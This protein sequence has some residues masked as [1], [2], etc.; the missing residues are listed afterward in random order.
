MTNSNNNNWQTDKNVSGSKNN[1]TVDFDWN[2]SISEPDLTDASL[3]IDRFFIRHIHEHVSVDDLKYYRRKKPP[4][5]HTRSTICLYNEDEPVLPFSCFKSE[6]T[7]KFCIPKQTPSSRCLL[8][9]STSLHLEGSMNTKSEQ[10]SQYLPYSQ[11][12]I[13]SC[14][15]YPIKNPESLHFIG[16]TEMTLGEYRSSF[17]SYPMVDRTASILPREAFKVSED[18]KTTKSVT[19]L[20]NRPKRELMASRT[21]TQLS[22][23]GGSSFAPSEYRRQYVEFRIE[24][25]HSIPQLSH[26]KI[27]GDFKGI[28][29]Y[30]DNYRMYDS[31]SKS[32]PIKKADNLTISGEV[33]CSNEVPEY[34]EKFKNP[35]KITVEKPLKTQDHLHPRGE[36]TKDV[37]EYFES[38]RDPQVKDKPER[39]KCR[40]PYLRLKGKLEFNPEYR[41]TYLDF[42]RSRPVVKK[43]TSSIRLQKNTSPR[44]KFKSSSPNRY[45]EIDPTLPLTHQPEYR[46]AQYNY[47]I[48]ERTPPKRLV[49]TLTQQTPASKAKGRENMNLNNKTPQKRRTSRHGQTT[50]APPIGEL[51][52]KQESFENVGSSKKLA[53]FG[54]RASITHPST[55]ARDKV[56]IIE[57]NAK[58]S[59]KRSNNEVLVPSRRD[60]NKESFVVLKEPCRKSA[61]MKKSWYES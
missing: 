10:Q 5:S 35:L 19:A 9:R 23:E 42:P 58:Y 36:F 21:K 51:K 55:N 17:I 45:V 4:D 52:A 3:S 61:W 7:K 24:K 38:F 18:D 15:V 60:K 16:E 30:Q 14:R 33:S 8:R 27:H 25:A 2:R 1:R 59:T 39:G 47:Q 50:V 22:M 11:E 37:P 48:R 20:D 12:D 29:E 6:Y 46:R 31:Y 49:D 40:E 34:R 53:K 13:Q 41:S 54:R 57:G 43:A 44:R 32:A 28:P 26:I 56:S